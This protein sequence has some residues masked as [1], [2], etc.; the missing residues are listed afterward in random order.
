MASR[1]TV[2]GALLAPLALRGQTQADA[3][4]VRK[5]RRELLLLSG[6][7]VMRTYA[8]ALGRVPSGPKQRQGDG[9]TPEGGYT[10]SGRNLHSAYHRSLRISYPNESDRARARRAGVSPGGDIM[11]HG[12]PNGLGS[13][14]AAHRLNDWTEGCIAV[15][16][17]E[18]EEIWRLAPDGTPIRI[19]P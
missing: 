14:G 8:I 16:N 3:I 13:L 17:V 2:L 7:R 4:L 18:I 5:A 10:I 1:R 6:G 19:E 15:T 9:K 12:L 11:I